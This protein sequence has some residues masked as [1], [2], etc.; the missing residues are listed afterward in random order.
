M[1]S[2]I[3]MS[4]ATWLKDE[5]CT[6]APVTAL[7]SV[8][9]GGEWPN[10]V[11]L[12]P[13]GTVYMNYLYAIEYPCCPTLSA[14]ETWEDIAS[15]E[16]MSFAQSLRG[17]FIRDSDHIIDNSHLIGHFVFNS[18]PLPVLN[19]RHEVWVAAANNPGDT[20]AYN[21]QLRSFQLFDV[22]G[23]LLNAKKTGRNIIL[24]KLYYITS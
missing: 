4:Y 15:Q 9:L 17:T 20:A 18:P 1:K 24:P 22:D 2:A 11:I 3:S 14:G 10:L 21:L 19:C 12:L 13:P 8:K 7:K 6:P 23:I 5:S 16:F